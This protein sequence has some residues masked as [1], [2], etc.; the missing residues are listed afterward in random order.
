VVDV[1]GVALIEVVGVALAGVAFVDVP[2]VVGF[3]G[4]E[5]VLAVR[6]WP[7][8][9]PQAAIAETHTMVARRTAGGFLHHR[10]TVS[11]V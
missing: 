6:G 4:A 8:D 5:E 1:V 9:P 2:V 10:V 3:L 11:R 7:P